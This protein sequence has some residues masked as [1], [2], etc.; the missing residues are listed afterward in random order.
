M[1]RRKTRLT[2]D[3]P[4]PEHL[5]ERAAAQ[6]KRVAA[7]CVRLKTLR[8]ADLPALELLVNALAT[9]Q[10]AREL[11][12]GGVT[13]NTGAGGVKPHPAVRMAETARAQAIALL[14][15]FGLTPRGRKGVAE[16][17]DDIY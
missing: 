16:V 3:P 10:E 7:L 2:K 5:S 14:D 1:P 9:E 6:W 8:E 17:D 12:K 15:R 4:P 13:V 11:L